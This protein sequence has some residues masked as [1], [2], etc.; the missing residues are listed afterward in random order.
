[1]RLAPFN[2]CQSTCAGQL[3]LV[4]VAHKDLISQGR[5]IHNEATRLSRA[6]YYWGEIFRFYR[7]VVYLLPYEI[8]KIVGSRNYADKDIRNIA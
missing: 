2:V 3:C 8:E 4:S 5:V 1:M 6:F 7:P